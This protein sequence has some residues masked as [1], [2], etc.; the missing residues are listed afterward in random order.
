MYYYIYVLVIYV[1]CDIYLFCKVKICVTFTASLYLW[2]RLHSRPS[3]SR[4]YLQLVVHLWHI[5]QNKILNENWI[6]VTNCDED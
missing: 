5:Y 1:R 4:V 6:G 3:S 2:N